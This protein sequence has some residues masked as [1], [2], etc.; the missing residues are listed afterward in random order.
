M[1]AEMF[2]ANE[3]DFKALIAQNG[4]NSPGCL[5]FLKQLD[6]TVGGI[7]RQFVVIGGAPGS[8]KSTYAINIAYNNAIELARSSCILELEM[9]EQAILTRL[10]VRHA[11]HPRFRRFTNANM[12]ITV[13]KCEKDWLSIEERFFLFDIVA[14]DFNTNQGYGKISIVGLND[15]YLSGKDLGQLIPIVENTLIRKNP[16]DDLDLLIIDYIQIL[17]RN[18]QYVQNAS[19][20]YKMVGDLAHYLKNLSLS[21]GPRGL[22]IIALSQLNRKSYDDVKKRIDNNHHSTGKYDDLYDFTCFAESSEVSNAADV[23]I[24]L[25]ADDDLKERK[26]AMVQLLKNRNGETIETPFEVLALPKYGYFGD[27]S[28]PGEDANCINDL[29]NDLL[30]I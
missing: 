26:V 1:E 12:D 22:S 14:N 27:C 9:T 19:D 15:F 6:D 13:A 28:H 3:T 17:A 8:Y 11:Q 16:R 18:A 29:I 30:R 4:Q 24:T 2:I 5:L 23:A 25:Y 20:Q 21:Y 7:P 10:L